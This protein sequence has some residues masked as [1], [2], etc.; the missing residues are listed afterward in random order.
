VYV[1]IR[2]MENGVPTRKAIGDST[3]SLRSDAIQVDAQGKLAT[4]FTFDSP[5]YVLPGREYCFSVIPEGN[6]DEFQLWLAE[7]GQ[8]DIS[9]TYGSFR[10]DKQPAAG[11]LFTSSNDYNWSVRQTQDLKYTIYVA[12]HGSNMSGVATLQNAS[13]NTDVPFS[14]MVTNIGTIKPVSTGI[15]FSARNVDISAGTTNYIDVN[16]LELVKFTERKYVLDSAQE[17]SSG[18]KSIV[19][20]ATMS[21]SNKY[22]TPVIDLERAQSII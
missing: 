15:A 1:Q 4:T 21:T 13:S 11:V 22:V 17:I 18:V 7:L 5:I 20:K 9:G 14:S 10:I 16:N 2:E 8:T 12:N 3:A 6:S 19:T